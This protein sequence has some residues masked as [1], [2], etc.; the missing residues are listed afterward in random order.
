MTLRDHMVSAGTR[1]DP[2]LGVSGT[3]L[4]PSWVPHLP[5]WPWASHFPSLASVP[6]YVIF[7]SQ[8]RC[9]R[10]SGKLSELQRVC[11]FC[12]AESTAGSRSCVE[13]AMGG[14][15]GVVTSCLCK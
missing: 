1:T 8:L 7:G 3:S 10:C 12:H 9:R 2:F 14:S 15:D 5:V 11:G 6:T 13:W 4:Q